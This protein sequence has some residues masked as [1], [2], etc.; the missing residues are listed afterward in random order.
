MLLG[1]ATTSG[2]AAQADHKNAARPEVVALPF[3]KLDPNYDAT[4]H[5]DFEI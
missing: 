1:R 5:P 2:R 3:H 4:V